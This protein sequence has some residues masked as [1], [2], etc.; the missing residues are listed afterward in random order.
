MQ[1][2][3]LC[4]VYKM[5]PKRKPSNKKG[6]FRRQYKK[7]RRRVE[8]TKRRESAEIQIRNSTNGAGV[9][10]SSNYPDTTKPTALS[11]TTCITLLPLRSYYRMSRGNRKNQMI[12]TQIFSKD[13]YLKGEVSPTPSTSVSDKEVYFVCGWVKD[14]LGYTDFTTPTVAT[15]TRSNLE[16]FVLN[17]VKEHFDTEKDFLRYREAKKDNI[18]ITK[19]QR[20]RHP[21]DADNM[22]PIQLR[23]HWSVNRKV[24]YTKCLALPGNNDLIQNSSST[25]GVVI[26]MTD[27]FTEDVDKLGGDKGGFL[28]LESWLPFALI[29]Q[30]DFT[31]GESGAYVA[32]NDIHYFTG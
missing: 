25:P 3:S 32:Y 20:L 24:T 11:N 30:K 16:S 18:K 13:L 23:G 15:A 2:K 21:M 4:K 29:Y 28:P 12:G 22:S 10:F 27:T 8:E 5:P 17:Q 7:N 9:T 19:Y 1:K 14:K 31:L 26:D 6:D